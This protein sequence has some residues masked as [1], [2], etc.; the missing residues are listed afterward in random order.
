MMAF[1]DAQLQKKITDRGGIVVTKLDK[2]VQILV[3][4][5]GLENDIVNKAMA[6]N[7]ILIIT[8]ERFRPLYIDPVKP[9]ILNT[10]YV[11]PLGFKDVKLETAIKERG[12]IILNNFREFPCI[13]LYDDK[14]DKQV[15]ENAKNYSLC[16][17]MKVEEFKEIYINTPSY[18]LDLIQMTNTIC[19]ALTNKMIEGSITINFFLKKGD[20]IEM[21]FNMVPNFTSGFIRKAYST[22][23]ASFLSDMYYFY[24][25]AKFD[26]KFEIS[27]EC[28]KMN[29]SAY[30]KYDG[31]TNSELYFDGDDYK[32]KAIKK[33]REI[34]NIAC[35][36][37][38]Y[39]KCPI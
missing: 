39:I 2:K 20:N 16:R 29:E 35:E 15:I 37:T 22:H 38:K 3:T 13:L 19:G 14:S 30:F 33:L 28:S 32:P 24:K 4:K 27:I 6:M 21:G 7:S 23:D 5:I 26:D 17:V 18:L 11:L 1:P 36:V 10:M 31:K 25:D 34:Y 8:E 12:G 9:L